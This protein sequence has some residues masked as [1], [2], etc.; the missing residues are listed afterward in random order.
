MSELLYDTWWPK[1]TKRRHTDQQRFSPPSKWVSGES[2]S[3]CDVGVCLEIFI[4][5][6]SVSLVS[7]LSLPP[8][9]PFEDM[10]MLSSKSYVIWFGKKA[11]AFN[12]WQLWLW[13][14]C[15]KTNSRISQISMRVSTWRMC[16]T[17]YMYCTWSNHT[18]HTHSSD[19][20][21]AH[22]QEHRHYCQQVSLWIIDAWPSAGN[23]NPTIIFY[24]TLQ[25]QTHTTLLQ[26]KPNVPRDQ[27]Q[28]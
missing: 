20:V 17:V 4:Y 2:S 22:L 5:A 14:L 3:R 8:R 21:A 13:L 1:L 26:G 16:Y 19:D 11:S 6:L 28:I 9:Q 25:S 27:G 12:V 18:L 7:S 23:S 24:T 15:L 10:K